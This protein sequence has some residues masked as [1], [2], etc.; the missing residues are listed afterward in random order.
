MWVTTNHTPR[1]R[2]NLLSYY[3]KGKYT[4]RLQKGNII[5]KI[6]GQPDRQSCQLT[7]YLYDTKIP[8]LTTSTSSFAVW[9]KKTNLIFPAHTPISIQFIMCA[10]RYQWCE[11][12][13]VPVTE[14]S[15]IKW[16]R[17]YRKS[18]WHS[19]FLFSFLLWAWASVSKL[20]VRD[21]ELATASAKRYLVLFT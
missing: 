15:A 1:V 10:N 3:T 4:A 20:W 11:N 16:K 17:P 19:V 6:Y 2:G 7:F 5:L 12:E 9:V 8:S 18:L 14:P 21:F 13:A